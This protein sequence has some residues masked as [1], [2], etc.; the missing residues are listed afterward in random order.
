MDELQCYVDADFAG[1]YNYDE[2]AL[3]TLSNMQA[4]L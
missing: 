1:S 2:N 4:V 3:D